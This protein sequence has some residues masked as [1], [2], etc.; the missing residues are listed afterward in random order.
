MKTDTS[1]KGLESLIVRAMTGR[2]DLLSPPH[3]ATETSVPVS[4]GTGWLLSD[5]S[6]YDREH[7]VDLVQLR[8]FLMATQPALIE[9]LALDRAGPV[10]LKFLTRL[11][12]E[13]HKRGVIDV[14]RNGVKH[15]SHDVSLFFGTPTPGNA[16][17]E[18]LYRH[19][20]FSVTRQL[21][22]SRDE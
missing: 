4:G 11:Q 6:H 2:P 1:E 7:C 19:N 22:Y 12:G 9:A 18:E 3:V 13:V 14:L 16:K 15:G 20:R 5:A 17:A 21:R 10:R 8:G